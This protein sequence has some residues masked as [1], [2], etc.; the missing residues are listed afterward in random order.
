MGLVV[1]S[2]VALSLLPAGV[3]GWAGGSSAAHA[4]AAPVWSVGGLDA[5]PEGLPPQG[6]TVCE[7]HVLS[8]WPPLRGASQDTLA[9]LALSPA[10]GADADAVR[11]P[12]QLAHRTAGS[13]SPPAA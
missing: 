9:H 6:N 5:D 3:L 12:Q 10:P 7:H 2:L 1:L 8:L 11:D 4:A 13:R